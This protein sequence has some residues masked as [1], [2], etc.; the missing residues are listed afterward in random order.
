MNTYDNPTGSFGTAGLGGLGL[1]G[2][3]GSDIFGSMGLGQSTGGLNSANTKPA[4]SSRLAMLGVIDDMDDDA[5]LDFNASLLSGLGDPF[6]P[7]ASIAA[8][9]TSTAPLPATATSG[10]G[11]LGFG[12]LGSS[13]IDALPGLSPL[14]DP[15][16]PS[17][18]GMP[19]AAGVGMGAGMG[20]ANTASSASF[21]V[22]SGAGD[23]NLSSSLLSLLG[24]G[25]SQKPPSS[26]GA[27]PPVA[28]GFGGLGGLS[29]GLS[30]SFNGPL[31]PET[32]DENDAAE[33]EEDDM[34]A[35][36]ASEAER[37]LFD[38][39]FVDRLIEVLRRCGPDGILGAQF[40]DAYRKMFGEKLNLENKKGRKVKLV[41]ILNGHPNAHRDK[42]GI[43]RWYYREA[44]AVDFAAKQAASVLPALNEAIAGINKAKAAPAKAAATAAAAASKPAAAAAPVYNGPPGIEVDLL[45]HDSFPSVAWLRDYDMHMYRW[46]GNEF[47]WTEYAMRLRPDIAAFLEAPG[48]GDGAPSAALAILRKRSGC[49]IYIDVDNLY[50]KQEKFLVFV[51]GDTGKPSNAAMSVALDAASQMFRIRLQ[52]VPKGSSIGGGSGASASVDSDDDEDDDDEANAQAHMHGG[53]HHG[54]IQHILDIPQSAVG[55]IAGKNGKKLHAMRKKSGAYIALVSKS[56]KVAAKLTISGVPKDVEVALS[57]VR[58]ALS[59]PDEDA[60]EA[61]ASSLLQG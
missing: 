3:G 19:G 52:N 30:A 55:L 20:V 14:A 8:P 40:P 58:Q 21:G 41:H 11:G 53:S 54:R 5:P 61:M 10:L 33:V 49:D 43:V 7:S 9:V 4:A 44:G 57:M 37:A 32:S 56:R 16:N 22:G 47:E 48:V 12:G 35:F 17:S 25:S 6:N 1:G 2:L 60:V 31:V 34:A 59:E 38:P 26:A 24:S 13:S 46:A 50:G 27:N 36:A 39:A 29:G 18:F 42:T 23:M 51:R 28:P 45:P 15:F